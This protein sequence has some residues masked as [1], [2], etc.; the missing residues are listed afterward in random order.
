MHQSTGTQPVSRP[1]RLLLSLLFTIL[2]LTLFACTSPFVPQHE[3][4]CTFTPPSDP[5]FV[6][7]NGVAYIG[8]LT[9]VVAVRPSDGSQLWK[10]TVGGDASYA[11]L[12]DGVLYVGSGANLAALRSS[13][14]QLLWQFKGTGSYLPKHRMIQHSA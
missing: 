13:D 9:S 11:T 1:T 2:T 4:A 14:G 8:M 10:A 5:S 12:T 6:V 3:A 7:S